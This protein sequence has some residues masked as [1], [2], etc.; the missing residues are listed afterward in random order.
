MKASQIIYHENYNSGTIDN[1]IAVIKLATALTLGST[2]AKAVG[3]P[4]Q[5]SDPTSGTNVLI[6]GW[7]SLREG[8][9][10][11]P[12]ALQAVTVP[13]VARA[14]CNSNYD[15]GIT[16]NM[17]CAGVAAGGKDACQGDSGGPVVVNNQL[18]G[19]VSWGYGCARPGYPGVYTRVGNYISWMSGKGVPV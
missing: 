9:S 17:F 10:S 15:G 11:L 13:I 4:S 19:A 2:N 1:D 3:L 7:G 14:T 5:G 18:V 6:T 16:N 12:S 8:S